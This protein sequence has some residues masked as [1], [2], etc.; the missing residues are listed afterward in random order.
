MPLSRFKQTFR[1]FAPCPRG[2]ESV[3]AAELTHL[4]GQLVAIVEGGVA[5]KGDWLT[6]LKANL[7]SRIASRILWLVAEKNYRTEKDI[8][9]LAKSVEWE[10]LFNLEHTIKVN[11]SAIHSPLN[12]LDFAGLTVKDAICDRFR[13]QTGKRPNV[14]TRTP[15]M[16]IH[17]FLTDKHATLYLDTSGESLFKRGYR[18][19]QGEA[20]LRENLAAGILALTQWQPS[21]ALYDPMCGSGTFLI[22]AAQIA[23]NIAPGHNRHFAFEKINCFDAEQWT[24]YRA[25]RVQAEKHKVMLPLYGSDLS[26]EMI[27]C[28]RQNLEAAGL[29]DVV[30]LKQVNILECTAPASL[31]VMVTNPPYGV[32]LSDQQ[33]LDKLYPQMGHVLK[34]RFAGWRA[35]LLSADPMLAKTIRLAASKRTPLFNGGLE[36]RLL[37][38]KLIAGS[39]RKT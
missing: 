15:D 9:Q 34:Q 11:V 26:G 17:L 23:L 33:A 39:N 14:E 12:S 19:A 29:A 22:E 25:E 37:E 24:T 36:C 3:L 1:L 4:G 35:Y 16:R 2:L 5:F 8:Y 7:E 10:A 30:T 32:R 13:E 38:Y 18:I 27:A 28:T 31:G 21:E 20:P 6:L